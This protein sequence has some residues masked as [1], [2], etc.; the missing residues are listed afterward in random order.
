VEKYLKSN[1]GVTLLELLL[2]MTIMGA[3]VMLSYTLYFSGVKSFNFGSNHVKIEQNVRL[4]D[5]IFRDNI[6]NTTYLVVESNNGVVVIDSLDEEEEVTQLQHVILDDNKIIHNDREI[7]VDKITDIRIQIE[8]TTTNNLM[9]QFE[10]I[11]NSTDSDYSFDRSI[12]LNNLTVND[13][14]DYENG[15][16]NFEGDLKEL[17]YK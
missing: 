1:K 13:I 8:E 11:S 7:P 14:E 4:L 9:L 5:N 6:R 10:V 12:L 3:L 2:V 17:Y 16:F 15:I